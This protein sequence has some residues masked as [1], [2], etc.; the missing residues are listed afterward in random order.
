MPNTFKKKEYAD[1]HFIYGFCNGKGWLLWWNT[2][3]DIHFAEFH[4]AKHLATHTELGGRLVP[5]HE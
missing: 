5:S 4:T 1:M 2:N 3:N